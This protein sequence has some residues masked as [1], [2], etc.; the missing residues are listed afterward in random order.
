VA[1]GGVRKKRTAVFSP[2]RCGGAFCLAPVRCR[3][4]VH[5]RDEKRQVLR[6][7]CFGSA[8]CPA[9]PR[10][11]FP[12]STC[13]LAAAGRTAA[14]YCLLA[15]RVLPRCLASRAVCTVRWLAGAFCCCKS[16]SCLKQ[17]RHARLSA[18]SLRNSAPACACLRCRRRARFERR[19]AIYLRTCR[20]A[21]FTLPLDA[22]CGVFADC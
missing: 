14:C 7:S 19:A 10:L 5:M 17:P 13:F 16:A 6:H 4:A 18:A 3:H 21:F 22:A 2:L 1:R 12:G 11:H 9:L 20:A 8:A 15:R